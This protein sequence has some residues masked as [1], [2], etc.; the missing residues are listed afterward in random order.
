MYYHKADYL[1]EVKV[2]TSSLSDA[3]KIKNLSL[4]TIKQDTYNIGINAGRL[5]KRVI[6]KE[7]IPQDEM[8]NVVKSFLVTGRTVG[9][10]P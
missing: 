9:R 8:V 6:A 4:T 7:D 2:I 3:E 5:L 10:M 1:E